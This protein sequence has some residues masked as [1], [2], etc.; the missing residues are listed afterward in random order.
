MT[1]IFRILKLGLMLIIGSGLMGLGLQARAAV[2]EED[3]NLG[4]DAAPGRHGVFLEFLNYED[5]IYSQ[6]K[7]TEVGDATKVDVGLRYQYSPETFARLRFVTD[8]V[9]NRFNNKTSKFE[10]LAGHKHGPWYFQ[11]DTDVLTDDGP[12]G[13]TSIGMDLTSELTSI[14]YGGDTFDFTFYPFNFDGEVGSEFNT[15]DVT[16]IYFISDA[17]TTVNPTQLG[18]EKIIKKTIPGFELAWRFLEDKNARVYVGLGAASFLYPMNSSFNIETAPTADRWERREDVGY[19]AGFTYQIPDQFRLKLQGAAHTDTLHTGSLLAGAASVYCIGRL[20]FVILENEWTLSKAGDAP[21]RLSRSGTWFEDVTPYQP[22]YADVFGQH[23]NWIGKTDYATSFRLG[24]EYNDS[25]TPYLT[26]KYQ[27]P[28]FIF[29]DR[30]SAHRLRTGDE[31]DSHGGLHRAGFG[32]FFY[33]GNFVVNPE[34]EF[35]RAKNAVFAN[36]SDVRT[37]RRLASFS[38]EDYQLSLLITYRVDGFLS[39]RP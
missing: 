37:D 20:G 14:S 34:F 12:T 8:P 4:P 38:N 6:S 15:W 2:V 23:Q 7:K 27:G 22:I 17:P 13:G 1:G 21:Y 16:R 18:N 36:A 35:F 39:F 19:K 33:S 26:Y 31:S 32:V 5:Y 3:P 30:E 28:N 11:M 29:R 24:Y 9:E 10:I 25:T